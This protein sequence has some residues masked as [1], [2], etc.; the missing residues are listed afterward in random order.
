MANESRFSWLEMDDSGKT[1]AEQ[2]QELFSQ[3]AKAAQEAQ[4]ALEAAQK[5]AQDALAAAAKAKADAEAQAAE[6]SRLAQEEA[7]RAAALANTKLAYRPLVGE[8]KTAHGATGS[9]RMHRFYRWCKDHGTGISD[10][11]TDE[12]VKAALPRLQQLLKAEQEHLGTLA[13]GSAE[14]VIQAELVRDIKGIMQRV[15]ENRSENV[16][17]SPAQAVAQERRQLRNEL[18]AVAE[19]SE[20]TGAVTYWQLTGTVDRAKL[21]EEYEKNGIDAENL[22]AIASPELALGRA[23]RELQTRTRLSRKLKSTGGWAVVVEHEVAGNLDYQ[24]IV[25]IFLQ[26][27]K[28]KEEVKF[29][30]TPGYESQAQHEYDRVMAEYDKQRESLTVVDI[31]G[32]LVK[33]ANKLNAVP[34]RDRGGIYFVPAGTVESFRKVKAA[35]AAVSG[36][37]VYE[38]P[39]MKSAETIKSIFDAIT[40]DAQAFV[41]EVEAELN[42]DMGTRAA[43]NR[44]VEVEAMGKKVRSYEG[45]LKQNLKPMLDKLSELHKRLGSVT[46]RAAQLEID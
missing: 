43:K 22:P 7:A 5:A 6:A 25:R 13:V 29:E 30:A 4:A 12:T 15:P 17:L 11:S 44:Q 24:Q 26:G 46:T 42:S 9:P 19:A 18:I 28:G 37:V 40:R 33:L 14:G 10:W 3:K 16:Q 35:L 8:Y 32:W 31:S 39:A 36:N 1:A 21:A 34:L 2:A 27:E 38:I 41:D 23:M 20:V 45:L